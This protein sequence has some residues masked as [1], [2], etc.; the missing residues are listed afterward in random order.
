[1]I[2]RHPSAG[3]NHKAPYFW[4]HVDILKVNPSRNKQP[5]L[6]GP[7]PWA[8]CA[9]QVPFAVQASGPL[10][11][12]HFGVFFIPET[13]HCVGERVLTEVFPDTPLNILCAQ[14]VFPFGCK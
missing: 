13:Q 3:Q 1:M 4:I 9:L 8:L 2:T 5:S 11:W 10:L 6:L 7:S 12:F 14:L